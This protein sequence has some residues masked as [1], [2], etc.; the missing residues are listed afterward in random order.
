MT[1]SAELTSPNKTPPS[2]NASRAGLDTVF[3][4]RRAPILKV[5]F[6]LAGTITFSKG[7]SFH[8]LKA[9]T[10]VPTRMTDSPAIDGARACPGI[11]RRA[12]FLLDYVPE[13]ENNLTPSET[14]ADTNACMQACTRG[15]TV[16]AQGKLLFTR[17]G[18]PPERCCAH[19]VYCSPQLLI[20]CFPSVMRGHPVCTG[21]TARS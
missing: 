11:R 18:I 8:I 3:S 13:L 7:E 21:R 19:S 17:K 4:D 9:V 1:L 5:S 2:A 6:T 15:H 12:A 20:S 16:H 14:D 10:P